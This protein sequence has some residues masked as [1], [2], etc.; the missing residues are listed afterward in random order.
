M[1]DLLD[2]LVRR[3]V[4]IV[5]ARVSPYFSIRHGPTPHHGG[6]RREVDFHDTPRSHRGGAFGA[7]V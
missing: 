6:C 5:F 1:R 4:R 3:R 2:E 7:H